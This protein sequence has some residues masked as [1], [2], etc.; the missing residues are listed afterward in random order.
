MHRS[1]SVYVALH[2]KSEMNLEESATNMHE[3]QAR[4]SVSAR[5]GG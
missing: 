3:T 2:N 5:M 1:L 4:P